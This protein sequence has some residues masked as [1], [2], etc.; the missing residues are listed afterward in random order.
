MTFKANIQWH[1]DMGEDSAGNS[2]GQGHF[3]GAMD[4]V[5]SFADGVGAN[6]FNLGYIAERT[7]TTGA[8]DSID[9]AGVLS[10]VLGTSFAAVELAAIAII[11]R[12]IDGTVNTT[13]L[14]IGGGSNPALGLFSSMI[15][16]PGAAVLASCGDAGGLAVVTPAT[17][18]LLQIVNSAGASAKYQFAVLGRSS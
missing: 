13:N 17:G 5:Q 3:T 1:L 10:S 15:L 8:T 12:A 4:F 9:L 7:V 6:Q 2:F 14:T 11:N 16:R 18:D